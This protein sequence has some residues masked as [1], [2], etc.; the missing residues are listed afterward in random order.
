[1][2]QKKLEFFSLSLEKIQDGAYG[3]WL[4]PYLLVFYGMWRAGILT[5]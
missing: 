2:K 3:G 1:M 4:V 5:Q